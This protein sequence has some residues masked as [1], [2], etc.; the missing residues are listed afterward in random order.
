MIPLALFSCVQDP[1]SEEQDF[2]THIPLEYEMV[3]EE[4]RD[5]SCGQENYCTQVR[6]EYPEITAGSCSPLIDSL[7]RAF[8]FVPTFGELTLGFTSTEDVAREFIGEYRRER[9]D[10]PDM[11][12]VFELNRQ[13]QFQ[14]EGPGYSCILM[15]EYVYTGGAHGNSHHQFYN[16][17]AEKCHLLSWQDV[18]RS[19]SSDSLSQALKA[20][21]LEQKGLDLTT[22][23]Y[24]AG[25]W[26]EVLEPTNN[27]GLLEDKVVFFYNSYEVASYA[28]GPVEVQL[29]IPAD[30]AQRVAFR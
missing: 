1:V 2:S 24:D 4:F 12:G 27:F 30:F 19:W 23:L 17:D 16:I 10:F 26:V 6:F 18:F 28:A 20:S 11:A 22:D 7:S 29:P 21:Y 25:L 5:D 13:V 9:R 8:L 3:M 14:Y 15:S